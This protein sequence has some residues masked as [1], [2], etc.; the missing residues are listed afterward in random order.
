[1]TE[2]IHLWIICIGSTPRLCYLIVRVKH[3][4]L[5]RVCRNDLVTPKYIIAKLYKSWGI[6]IIHLFTIC[7]GIP[8][9]RSASSLSLRTDGLNFNIRL[10]AIVTRLGTHTQIKF[11]LS[12]LL[13][14]FWVMTPP[15]QYKQPSW[16]T[17]WKGTKEKLCKWLR[18]L[19]CMTI[20]R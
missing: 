11:S 20:K 19:N 17:M 5:F 12:V 8:R 10:H 3:A 16:N 6:R 9:P 14:P 7:W 4:N 1:M 13:D 15:W 18:K 2:L